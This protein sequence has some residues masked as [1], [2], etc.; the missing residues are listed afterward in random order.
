MPAFLDVNE[1][2]FV[3]LAQWLSWKDALS[4]RA[5]CLG[6]RDHFRTHT[7]SL[8]S[9]FYHG[10]QWERFYRA[11][12]PSASHVG[13]RPNA[14]PYLGAVRGRNLVS[15][16]LSLCG[17][18]QHRLETLGALEI[19]ASLSRLQAL[20]LSYNHLGSGG[21][22]Y[23]IRAVRHLPLLYLK[24]VGC[25]VR[26][27]P[28]ESVLSTDAL[29]QNLRILNLSNNPL[30]RTDGVTRFLSCL[31]NLE[32]IH[33]FGAE[34]VSEDA[35]NHMPSIRA[36]A[37]IGTTEHLAR[38]LRKPGMR[39][40]EM[41]I[42]TPSSQIATFDTGR[43]DNLHHLNLHQLVMEESD[44]ISFLTSVSKR[45][46]VSML[47]LHHT[48]V[49]TDALRCFMEGGHAE[50]LRHLILNDAHP[51]TWTGM[52][53][54]L[55]TM[56][57]RQV[58]LKGL[59]LY[60]CK[61][62]ILPCL[63]DDESLR[64]LVGV[65]DPECHTVLNLGTRTHSVC[66]PVL[67]LASVLENLPR[68]EKVNLTGRYLVADEPLWKALRS[69]TVLFLEK[70]TINWT[71][72]H[73]EHLEVVDISE[74]NVRGDVTYDDLFQCCLVKP[75]MRHL[76]SSYNLH[77]TDVVWPPLLMLECLSLDWSRLGIAFRL[78]LISALAQGAMPSLNTLSVK[79]IESY[80][81]GFV[82]KIVRAL[83]GGHRALNLV[84]DGMPLDT[85]T[86]CELLKE[87]LVDAAPED[88]HRV[89]FCVTLPY[90]TLFADLVEQQPGIKFVIHS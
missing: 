28:G 74:L 63:P 29:C 75:R 67:F 44:W 58:Q 50:W 19:L 40:V 69:A 12:T 86:S 85:E 43:L 36:I 13:L 2:V 83:R 82:I 61:R 17:L 1:H 38:W 25:R 81:L 66:N 57:K 7:R 23:A 26:D 54:V 8:Q 51:L 72:D 68:L 80:H 14:I 49:T 3:P 48:N 84:A 53:R 11:V 20:N 59:T 10:W 88:L 90:H 47:E 70:A 77:M 31:R 18:T 55:R 89:S 71:F 22:H 42:T 21:F 62:M 60:D 73:L 30:Q 45:A 16:D 5:T 35:A 65:M 56:Q 87:A 52:E 24:C 41:H 34:G 64:A 78:G 46:P 6:L 27:L 9:P 39:M 15:L 37:T 76:R 79:S 4:M 33:L 32:R